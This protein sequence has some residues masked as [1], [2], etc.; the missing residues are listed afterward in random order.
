MFYDK[1]ILDFL[2]ENWL[3]FIIYI[4]IIIVLFPIE[5]LVL[6]NIYGNL[7]ESIKKGN[8]KDNPFNIINNI[9][10][11]NSA[12]LMALIV[13]SWILVVF[14]DY[15]K[16]EVE[17]YLLPKYL[18]DIR[19]KFFRGT[20]NKHDEGNFTEV[21]SGEYLARI[22]ELSRNLRDAFMYLI[23]RFLPELTIVIMILIY[24]CFYEIEIGKIMLFSFILCSIISIFYGMT[25]IDLIIKREEHFLKI[26]ENLI[27]NFNNLMNIY[28]NNNSDSTV[29]GNA[30]LERHSKEL[31]NH[32]M[33]IENLALLSTQTLTILAYGVS[34][35]YLYQKL[36]KKEIKT[37]TAIAFILVLGQYLTYV[38][39]INW[40]FIH[41]IIFKSGIVLGSKKEM[42]EIF[43]ALDDDKEEI[44]FHNNNIVF[45]NIK[46]KYEGDKTNNLFDNFNLKV[47]ENE[48]IGIVGRSGSGKTTLAKMLVK[49]H[50]PNEGEIYIGGQ[51]ISN[52]SKNSLRKYVNYVNQKT[53]L[54]DDTLIYNLK[55]GNEKSDEEIKNIIK[56][57]ELDSVYSDLKD[58]YKTEVGINGGNLSLGMQKVTTLVRSTL[59]ESGIIIFDEPLAGLDEKTRTKV[60]KMIINECKTRTMIII[61][62]DQEILPYMDRVININELQ[63]K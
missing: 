16:G 13:I 40:G 46:F 3:V 30:D 12:G 48:K 22:M 63:K 14:T 35:Y 44:E 20:I 18:L 47:K 45:K 60:I 42:E 62:H 57:Y 52:I 29:Q 11:M 50:I 37:S 24:L 10:S 39:E 55:Y 26:N 54:F 19:D 51:E 41:Q 23:S 58:G 21:K 38:M 53:N 56:K 2:K 25:L 32:I 28:T 7:F 31:M 4:I 5:G 34:I 59:K 49:L 43:A 27:N 9:K 6:P 36:N 1:L 33:N 61:T 15:L 8:F 17:A